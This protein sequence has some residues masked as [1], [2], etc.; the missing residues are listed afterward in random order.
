MKPSSLARA[1]ESLATMR[2]IKVPKVG[3]CNS[4]ECQVL[5]KSIKTPSCSLS[6]DEGY[7]SFVQAHSSSPRSSS[8]PVLWLLFL[9][10]LSGSSHSI[11]IKMRF[12]SALALS[13]SLLQ[14]QPSFARPSKACNTGS[15]LRRAAYL[16]TNEEE[17]MVVS[18]PID[19][20]GMLS[21]G[22][23]VATG[24]AGAVSIDGSTGQP[25]GADPLVSQSAL[26]VAGMVSY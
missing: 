6:I 24:G 26:T 4:V 1:V 12:S 5:K 18:L 9:V 10:Y 20:K 17:N 8:Y 23:K 21:V 22:S 25:A 2:L 14:A 11:Q 19:D 16:L 15:P 7:Y 3:S 13:C